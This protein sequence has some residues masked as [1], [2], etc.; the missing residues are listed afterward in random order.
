M[1]QGDVIGNIG[2]EP[3]IYVFPERQESCPFFSSNQWL[4]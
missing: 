4:Q 3:E 1:N 2:N